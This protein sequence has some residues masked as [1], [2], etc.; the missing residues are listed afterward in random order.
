MLQPTRITSHSNTLIDKVF[1]N[2]TDPEIIS[3]NLTATIFD[4]LPHFAINPSMPDNISG[5]KSIYDRQWL[6][7][8]RENTI[9]DHLLNGRI[10]SKLI[11]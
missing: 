1:S 6:K 7:F 5:N 4:H 9:V 8:D 10:C 3:G 11:N 2:V